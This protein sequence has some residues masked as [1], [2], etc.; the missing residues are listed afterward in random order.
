MKLSSVGF[1]SM[2][3]SAGIMSAADCLSAPTVRVKDIASIQGVRSNHLYGYGLVIGLDDSGDGS[4]SEFTIQSISAMLQR[5]GINVPKADINTSNVAAVIVTAELPPF[6]TPGTRIDVTI[7]SI[8]DAESL[9]GGTLLL[10]P[11]QAV[12]GNIYALAQ[13]PVSLGGFSFGSGGGAGGASAVKNVPTTG[14]IPNGA[15]VEREVPITIVK[16]QMLKIALREPDFTTAKRLEESINAVFTDNAIARDAAMVTVVVP[17]S[18]IIEDRIVDFISQVEN[19]L[20]TPDAPAKIIINERTGTIVAGSN[21]RISVVA[22][23]HGNL[24]V[25]IKSK[26]VISQPN[27]FT[28]GGET[29]VESDDELLVNEQ[30][31]PLVVVQDGVTI[32]EVAKAL[33]ALGATPRD[34]IAIFQAM[35]KAGAIQAELILM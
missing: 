20:V 26:P 5:M 33:N 30:V 17:N 29:V 12:D 11:L 1:I 14:T 28:E 19:L 2:V 34:L 23:S 9:F 10:T 15:L 8:G 4:S 24:N 6:A 32:G 22:V 7:S 35:K 16:N 31:N 25:V 3:L 13:G 18:Y 21:V 27:S